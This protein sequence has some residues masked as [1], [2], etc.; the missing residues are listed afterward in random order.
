MSPVS[1]SCVLLIRPAAF[2]H[3][4]ETAASNAFQSVGP[5]P[6]DVNERARREH[7]GLVSALVDAGVETIVVDDTPVPPR[8]DALF[9]NNWVSFHEDGTVV[10]YPLEAPGRRLE[11]RL[12]VVE[13]VERRAGLAR[14]RLVDL[15]EGSEGFLEGTGSLVLDRPARR[16]FACL[17][18]RTAP[19]L[20][21]RFGHELEHEVVSFH[22]LDA[23]GRPI[24]HTNVMLALG[25]GLAV[26]C[27]ESIREPAERGRVLAALA[28]GG[29][30]LVEI[31]LEQVG[32][33][34]GNVLPL[35]SRDGE[36]RIVLSERARRAFTPAQT[37]VLERHGALV[38]AP[39]DT[40]ETIGGGSA[41]CMLAE[42]LGTPAPGA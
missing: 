37:R 24:Y 29:R 8:P 14:R 16:A 25:E 12:E 18:S 22:A 35:R 13:T 36:P 41:R 40:I 7:D 21:E 32:E 23:A 11:V 6:A 26:V 33:F 42:V 3:N 4:P 19:A 20:L 34:A 2:G 31:T 5:A 1:T 27:S 28:Q 38:S 17:S 9:P 10:L 30:E 39:L 15:R